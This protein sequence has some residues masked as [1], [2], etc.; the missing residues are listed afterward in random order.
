MTSEALL[1]RNFGSFFLACWSEIMRQK[2][3]Y[4][5][6]STDEDKQNDVSFLSALLFQWMNSVFKIGSERALDQNDFLPLSHENSACFLTDKLQATWNK[7]QYNCERTGKRPKLWKSLFK[8]LSVK[9]AMIIVLGY[10]LNTLYHLLCPLFLGYLVS[11]L[12]SAQAEKNLPLYGCVLALC[13]SAMMG[14][15]GMH[16]HNYRCILLG[17]RISSA[18]KGLVYRKVSRKM[19]PVMRSSIV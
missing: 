11:K 14:G 17:I 6:I 15:L 10:A 5:K 18:L 8:M 4:K 3:G 2:S 16:Q 7:D 19:R 1:Y 9:D 13:F 12:M